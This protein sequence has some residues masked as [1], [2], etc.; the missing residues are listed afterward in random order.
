MTKILQQSSFKMTSP[1]QKNLIPVLIASFP[2]NITK[3]FIPWQ[4][5]KKKKKILALN[6][7][8]DKEFSSLELDDTF[9]CCYDCKDFSYS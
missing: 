7:L 8:K 9:K 3:Y 6:L 4:Q 5:Q 2:S 1:N